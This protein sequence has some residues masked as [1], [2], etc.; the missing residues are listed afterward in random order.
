MIHCAHGWVMCTR[1]SDGAWSAMM[2]GGGRD[3]AVVFPV[4]GRR[5][6]VNKARRSITG[7]WGCVSRTQFGRR[8]GGGWSS[9]V[10]RLGFLP[11]AM[12]ARRSASWD[13]GG[14]RGSSRGAS[15]D[16]CGAVGAFGGGET[17]LYRRVDRRPSGGGAGSSPAL[18]G[19]MVGH[20]EMKLE[21]LGSTSEL[22][23]CA[24]SARL[25]FGGSEDG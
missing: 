5:T 20:G 15:I 1:T 3:G 17:A 18:W 13:A 9:T 10:G 12:A 6:G 7:V 11:A 4:R 22:L 16:W 24:S 19:M 25:G 2:D 21:G 8:R 23:R 14:W